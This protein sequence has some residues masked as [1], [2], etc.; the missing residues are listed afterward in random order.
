MQ[1]RPTP[2]VGAAAALRFLEGAV[3]G[4]IPRMTRSLAAIR[5]L[6]SALAVS[7][8]SC[9]GPSAPV[10]QGGGAVMIDEH[11]AAMRVPGY[12]VFTDLSLHRRSESKAPPE[13]YVAGAWYGAFFDA[14]G[15]VT[16]PK[17]SVP[18]GRSTTRGRLELRN[19]AFFRADDQR[20]R[21][22][23]YVEGWR[24]DDTGGF[25]PLGDVVWSAQ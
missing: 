11:P 15:G 9:G 10:D 19:R 16:G 12:L 2:R 13:P 7:A 5:I 25:Y 3:R 4:N 18:S 1:L 23:P 20:P 22:V 6:T 14:T 24:D 17:G 8:V 21:N